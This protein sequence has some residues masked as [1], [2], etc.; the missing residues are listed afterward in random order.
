MCCIV[1]P[2]PDF[3]KRWEFQWLFLLK[4]IYYC[5]PGSSAGKQ[6]TCSA[7]DPGLIPGLGRSA[8]RRDRLP[9][10]V[11]MDFHG[12]SDGKE[13]PAM[14]E[15]WV[16]SLGWGDPLKEGMATYSSILAWRIPRDRGAWWAA[17]H[18]T[19]FLKSIYYYL[20]SNF[21]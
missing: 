21:F 6:S 9:T 12:G 11:F 19:F 17:V 10:L 1:F 13:S 5:F 8:W 20:A 16:W 2:K 7:G 14:W 4:S 15:T 3:I 18:G